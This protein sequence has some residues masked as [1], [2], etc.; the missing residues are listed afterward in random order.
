[1]KKV[2]L[3]GLRELTRDMPMGPDSMTIVRQ[4]RDD[5]RY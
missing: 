4:M 2:D 1:M 5:A 3:A